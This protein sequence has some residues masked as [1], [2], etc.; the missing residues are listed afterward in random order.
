M[1]YA[2]VTGATGGIGSELCDVL[3]SRGHNLVLVARNEEKLES[4]ARKLIDAYGIEAAT[5]PCDL[6]EPGAADILMTTT[7]PRAQ[8]SCCARATWPPA[9]VRSARGRRR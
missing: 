1:A 4:L 6:A 3:A 2:L 8:G 7:S 9:R 5:I